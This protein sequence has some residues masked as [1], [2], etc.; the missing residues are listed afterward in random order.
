M[1]EQALLSCIVS[2]IFVQVVPLKI[3][4]DQGYSVSRL[5]VKIRNEEDRAN[6]GYKQLGEKGVG[7]ANMSLNSFSKKTHSFSLWSVRTAECGD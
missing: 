4:L 3:N 5:M 7:V 6:L 1:E 2:L